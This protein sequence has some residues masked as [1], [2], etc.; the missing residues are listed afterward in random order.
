AV[1]HA[2]KAAVF[3]L[4]DLAAFAFDDGLE[5]GGQCVHLLRADIL[6]RD[7]EMLIESHLVPFHY[8]RG[9]SGAGYAPPLWLARDAHH[10]QTSKGG[11]G[12][13]RPL[14]GGSIGKMAGWRK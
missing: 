9:D 2:P 4:L 13:P 1:R 3:L 5:V 8:G 7:Q 11:P 10:A 14:R 6:A 12:R